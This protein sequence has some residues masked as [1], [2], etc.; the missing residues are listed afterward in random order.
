[1]ITPGL[2]SISFRQLT[3]EKI[4][5]LVKKS[6]LKGIEWGGDKH[7]PHGDIETA[8][9]VKKLTEEA[10][11]EVAAYGS[12]YRT[13]VSEKEN[14]SF[15]S[16][17]N[18][19]VALGAKKIRVWAGNKDS[20]D[21]SEQDWAD[22]AADSRRIA[23]MAAAKGIMI[24]YEFHGGTLTNTYESCKKLLEMVAHE[25]VL[26]YWQ[27]IHG[28]TAEENTAGLKTILQWVRGA[29]VFH[30]WPDHTNR[31]PLS[32]GKDRWEMYLN[33]LNSCGTDIYALMEFVK[34]DDPQ[35]FLTDAQTF[36]ELLSSL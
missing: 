4:A 17:L 21:A 1:M 14:L 20:Q 5:E 33:T 3:P 12:Y 7:V 19:A 24:V 10:G 35:N 22:V 2:V 18:S 32:E 6:G 26:T 31:L 16:V 34:D 15:E 36:R 23:D 13:A 25:N 29:H 9:N 8:E 30:W 27:P 11:L 28:L